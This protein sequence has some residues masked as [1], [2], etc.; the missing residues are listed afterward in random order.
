MEFK[1]RKK[2][3]IVGTAGTWRET[4]WNDPDLDIWTLNDAYMLGFPRID[5]HFEMHPL[6]KFVFRPKDKK[7]VTHGDIPPG[8]YLRPEG[9]LEW[10]EEASSKDTL[11]VTQD[12]PPPSWNMAVKYPRAEMEQEFE[13][14][15]WVDKTWHR[16]YASSGPLWM[17]LLALH[18]GYEEIGIWGIH[19]ATEREYV[20]Q[21][22]NFEGIIYYAIGK[23]VKIYLPKT[24]PI[25]K[26]THTYC[27]EKRYS[28]EKD[29]LKHHMAVID[30]KYHNLS[31]LLKQRHFWQPKKPYTQALLDLECDKHELMT[32]YQRIEFADQ[33][34][35]PEWRVH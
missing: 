24:T 5:V 13:D 29:A 21:R 33:L 9:H 10:L 25:C 17:M 14:F 26:G 4:P 23:G 7:F 18:M 2:C 19:L 20:E 30:K 8:H 28:Q 6:D 31:T 35:R 11:I 3:A 27:Y 12:D 1:R 16:P 32:Q 15:L 34:E 22:P